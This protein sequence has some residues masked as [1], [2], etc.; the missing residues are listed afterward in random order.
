MSKRIISKG[1]FLA[2]F[3]GVCLT[4]SAAVL[5]WPDKQIQFASIALNKTSFNINRIASELYLFYRIHDSYPLEEECI[6]SLQQR[7]GGPENSVKLVSYFLDG[8]DHI[9]KYEVEDYGFKLSSAG[10]NGKFNDEDDIIRE[11]S[12]KDYLD[13]LRMNTTD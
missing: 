6:N 10:P 2:F 3:C 12:T 7:W 8:W 13:Y 5:V 4:I 9:L 11:F 1:E